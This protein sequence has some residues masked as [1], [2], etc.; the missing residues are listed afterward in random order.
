M[1]NDG[2]EP[3]SSADRGSSYEWGERGTAQWVEYAFP[4]TATVAESSVYWTA[5]AGR[6]TL[7]TPESWRLLYRARNEWKPVKAL[8]PYTTVTDTYNRVAFKPVTTNGL[9]LEVKFQ[10]SASAGISEWVV[11]EAQP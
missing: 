6:G 4:K 8:T 10:P 2:D 9:R 11:K 7:K 5:T 1:I 3:S